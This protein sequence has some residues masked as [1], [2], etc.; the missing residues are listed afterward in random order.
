MSSNKE[1]ANWMIEGIG[2]GSRDV[3]KPCLWFTVSDGECSGSLQV[4]DLE[5]LQAREIIGSEYEVHEL[6]GRM[7]RVLIEGGMVRFVKL[8]RMA[9]A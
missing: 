3:G 4:F 2:V 5:S 9:A 8:L 6:N 1:E 7:C